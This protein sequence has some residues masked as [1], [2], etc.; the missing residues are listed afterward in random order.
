MK[1]AID[2]VGRLIVEDEKEWE[3]PRIQEVSRALNMA[4][5]GFEEAHSNFLFEV[6]ELAIRNGQDENAEMC[7]EAQKMQAVMYQVLLARGEVRILS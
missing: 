6:C 7:A 3:V 2:V 4:M 5:E 1:E